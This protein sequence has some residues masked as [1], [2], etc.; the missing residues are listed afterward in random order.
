MSEISTLGVEDRTHLAKAH[1]I[2]KLSPYYN[3]HDTSLLGR[4]GKL[5][6]V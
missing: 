3:Q 4:L 5:W 2:Q 1:M 6:N